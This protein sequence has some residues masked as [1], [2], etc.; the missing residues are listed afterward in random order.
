MQELEILNG[1]LDMLLKKYSALLAEN[2]SLQQTL[3]KHLKVAEQQ[4]KKLIS[5]EEKMLNTQ[6][7][8][9]L[10]DDEKDAMRK[11]LDNVI[12]EIDKI[13]TTIND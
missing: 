2:K 11:Q 1:K 5:L 7:N 13:L 6:I 9:V 12:G 8:A 10:N 3:A 4:N